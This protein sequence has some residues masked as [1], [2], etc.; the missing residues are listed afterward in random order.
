MVIRDHEPNRSAGLVHPG[1]T[2][3]GLREVEG[4]WHDCNL[5]RRGCTNLPG[6]YDDRGGRLRRSGSE[7]YAVSRASRRAELGGANRASPS[8][9]RAATRPESAARRSLTYRPARLRSPARAR[10]HDARSRLGPNPAEAP[11]GANSVA[12]NRRRQRAT[13]H[14]PRLRRHKADKTPANQSFTRIIVPGG[15][16][17]I[18]NPPTPPS[19]SPQAERSTPSGDISQDGGPRRGRRGRLG[20]SSMYVWRNTRG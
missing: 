5:A 3:G 9:V 20:G 16:D 7:N 17:L 10:R 11:A 14:T 18:S 15:R 12:R 4:C 1:G 6:E 19:V 13:A 2:C 8:A